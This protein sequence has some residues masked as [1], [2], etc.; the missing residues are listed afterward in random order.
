M[1]AKIAGCRRIIGLDRIESRLKLAKELGCHEVIDGSKL[2][3]KTLVDAIKETAGGGGPTIT[4]DTSGAPPLIKSGLES[5]R[6][7]GK[8]VQVGSAPFDFNLEF[9][10][11]S[12]MVAGKQI[13]GAVEGQAYP[14]EFVPKMVKWYNEGRFPIDKLM[15]LMPAEKFEQ[16]LQEMHD[17]STIK[18]ILTWS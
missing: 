10:M 16:A 8:F 7:R 14:P 18:P 1:G 4:I 15:K 6:N 11:F 9:T 17:G 13:I 12:F 2:G 5:L 3:D